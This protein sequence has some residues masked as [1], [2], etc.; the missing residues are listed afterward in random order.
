MITTG[1]SIKT[2]N[3]RK[4]N[5]RIN[6]AGSWNDT[7]GVCLYWRSAF[8]FPSWVDIRGTFKAILNVVFT[9][10]TNGPGGSTI[11][12]QLIK[13]TVLTSEVSIKEKWWN[14]NCPL[15]LKT[16]WRSRN[17]G[18][19]I[20]IRLTCQKHG[21]FKMLPNIISARDVSQLSVAQSAVLA[22]VINAPSQ[23]NP[24]DYQ[25]DENGNL[26]VN[27]TEMKTEQQCSDIIPTIKTVRCW[28]W[29]RC[30]SWG[31]SMIRNMR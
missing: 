20:W 29:K 13:Q 10:T 12:Q 23:Y 21:E 22:A 2:S 27:P 5:L 15:S 28:S 30:I 3:S 16:E 8:L 17:F 7:T 19:H 14:G 1:T 18:R 25:T 31:I 4:Q 6:R 26:Y 9:G 11:T 24:Y